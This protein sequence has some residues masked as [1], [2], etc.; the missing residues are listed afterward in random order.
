[1]LI[2][3]GIIYILCHSD[4]TNA[5]QCVGDASTWNAGWGKC[6]TYVVGASNNAYCNEDFKDGQFAYE[7][8]KECGEC[9]V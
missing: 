5:L 3:L 2:L 6:A 8:C 1:M 7:V 9:G 4:S